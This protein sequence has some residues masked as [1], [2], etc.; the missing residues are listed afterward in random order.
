MK[1]FLLLSPLL[2]LGFMKNWSKDHDFYRRLGAFLGGLLWTFGLTIFYWMFRIRE[3]IEFDL[4]FLT[5]HFL[6]TEYLLF[7]VP[8]V[9]FF[10]LFGRRPSKDASMDSFLF[11]F[12]GLIFLFGIRD[13]LVYL[14]NVQATELFIIPLYR[15]LAIVVSYFIYERW[16]DTYDL[17]LKILWGL[18][19]F[20]VWLIFSVVIAFSFLGN[21]WPALMVFLLSGAALAHLYLIPRIPN[22]L[23]Q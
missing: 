6:S 8:N 23:K 3:Q 7:W 5:F 22:Y 19:P 9:V 14:P 1:L 20:G 21:H 18:A 13:T 15:L 11:W 17:Y 16:E 12:S 2:F 4:G 10:F